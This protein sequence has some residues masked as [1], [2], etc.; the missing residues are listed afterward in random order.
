[1][2]T[3]AR[4]RVEADPGTGYGPSRVKRQVVAFRPSTV[5]Y[6]VWLTSAAEYYRR[7]PDDRKADEGSLTSV[8]ACLAVQS[9]RH[10]LRTRGLLD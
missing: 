1:V 8:D 10:T 2:D 7:L 5:V 4:D 9:R 6:D 3:R